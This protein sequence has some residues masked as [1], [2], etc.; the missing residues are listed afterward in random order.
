MSDKSYAEATGHAPF[1]WNKWLDAA[2]EKE[3]NREERD[4][5]CEMAANWSLCA[6]GNACAIIPRVSQSQWD[7]DGVYIQAG[8]PVDPELRELGM[9][10]Y[11]A[12]MEKEY[13]HAKRILGEIEARA[14]IVIEQE[15]AKLNQK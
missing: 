7:D 11:D 9:D 3:P 15:L 13:K 6:C 10:F 12:V 2:I 1:D 8:A 14:V 5:K 4:M